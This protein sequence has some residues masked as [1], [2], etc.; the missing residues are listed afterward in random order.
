MVQV[1]GSA[2][3]GDPVTATAVAWHTE[4]HRRGRP[5]AIAAADPGTM[6]A[7]ERF[8][9][10]HSG[11]V[12][13]HSVDGGESLAPIVG[14]LRDR[15]LTLV[16]H[17]SAVGSDRRSLRALRASAHRALAADPAAREEL[18]GLGFRSVSDADDL[19]GLDAFADIVADAATME[20]LARHPGALVLAIGPVRPNR[21]IE[22]LLDA[23]AD[24]VT[25]AVPSAVLSV[26]GPVEP[27][28]RDRLHR[29]VT[30]GGL[31]ACEIV[32]PSDD[33]EVLARIEQ[34]AALVSLHPAALDPY[35]R[36]AARRRMP[37]VAPSDGRTAWIDRQLLQ[38][39]AI[40][41]SRAAVASAIARVL[42]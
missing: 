17:G 8:D 7:F 25:H 36:V 19:R 40:P 29:T 16:H 20:N 15:P 10:R 28:Y 32:A 5:S 33:G 1:V 3:A 39:I 41:C 23:F 22:I 6:R 30:R 12:V 4:A 26:C 9:P 37:I 42:T 18:R 2:R 38:P 11:E 27:W 21:G 13:V 35:A 24:V 14:M 31:R 34:A